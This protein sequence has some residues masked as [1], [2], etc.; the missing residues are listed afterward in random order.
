MTPH[1]N[2]INNILIREKKLPESLVG[3]LV[4]NQPMYNF[5]QPPW[6]CSEV[7]NIKE[8]LKVPRPI[9]QLKFGKKDT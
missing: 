4:N 5:R 6:I 2:H 1:R 3:A 7:L 8:R 9:K